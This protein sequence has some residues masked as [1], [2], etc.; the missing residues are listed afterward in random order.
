MNHSITVYSNLKTTVAQIFS[1]LSLKVREHSKGRKP[2]LN[3]IEAV[4]C[5]ILKQKQNIETK[6]SLFE[7]VEPPCTYN[8]FVRAING[9][10]KYVACIIGMVLK[11]LG[12]DAHQIK[13]TDATDIPVCLLK[14]SKR[15]RTMRGLAHYSK[16]GKGFFFGLKLHLSADVEGRVLALTFTP[17][18]SDDRA[19]FRKM[20]EKLKG[21]FVADAGYISKD[22]TRDFFIEGERVLITALRTNMKK[23]ATDWQSALLALRMK[24]EVHFRM[25]KVV[26]GIVTSLPR[27]ID[28][29][30]TH[31]LASI[32]AHLLAT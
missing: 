24:V 6:K 5:A 14:N 29:Y 2:T 27:S 10:G 28:G 7:I 1:T 20:N 15:H 22:L 19:L 25:L 23:L 21:L 30:L 18:N 3:N 11:A 17:G 26:Y 9:T 32:A 31:Y 16:T 13:F 4:T 12:R 8:T